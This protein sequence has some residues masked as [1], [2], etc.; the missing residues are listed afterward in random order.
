MYVFCHQELI[1]NSKYMMIVSQSY[2]VNT[3]YRNDMSYNP[4]NMECS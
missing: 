4:R 3:Q 2:S 1:T